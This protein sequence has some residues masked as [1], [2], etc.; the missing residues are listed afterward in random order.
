MDTNVCVYIIDLSTRVGEDHNEQPRCA[1][2]RAGDVSAEFTIQVL[3]DTRAE[4]DE[5]L[6]VVML[7]VNDSGVRYERYLAYGTVLDDD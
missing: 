2:I 7:A 3:A 6:A 5:I 1:V 4:K